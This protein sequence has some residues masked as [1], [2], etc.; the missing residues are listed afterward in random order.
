MPIFFSVSLLDAS[1]F[2]LPDNGYGDGQDAYQVVLDDH[3]NDSHQNDEGNHPSDCHDCSYHCHCP[4]LT[5]HPSNK[6]FNLLSKFKTKDG[7][8]WN[9]A[10]H[11]KHSVINPLFRPPINS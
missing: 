3:C 2:C 7:L 4:H 10:N 11:Y 1:G 6:S 5:F 8:S 9:Y